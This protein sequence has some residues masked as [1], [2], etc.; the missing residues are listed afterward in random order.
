MGVRRGSSVAWP[1]MKRHETACWNGR[2]KE[3]TAWRTWGRGTSADRWDAGTERRGREG[4][5]SLRG[6]ACT[7]GRSGN[8]A[9]TD[10][11]EAARGW[12]WGGGVEIERLHGWARQGERDSRGSARQGGSAGGLL[13]GVCTLPRGCTSRR[14]GQGY[15]DGFQQKAKEGCGP[16]VFLLAAGRVT[17]PYIKCDETLV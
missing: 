6:L 1:E 17:W 2:M 3:P 16:S 8:T 4:V 9:Y 7:T 14:E 13:Q 5:W 15:Y 11:M 10:E 12:G